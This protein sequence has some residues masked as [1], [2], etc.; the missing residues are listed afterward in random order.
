MGGGDAYVV[1]KRGAF[2]MHIGAIEP[3]TANCWR[4]RCRANVLTCWLRCV[5][6]IVRLGLGWCCWHF[7]KRVRVPAVGEVPVMGSCRRL[8]PRYCRDVA[9]LALDTGSTIAS[10]AR[11]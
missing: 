8:T 4:I 9:S 10:V 11:D 2:K 3:P 7:V 1:S 5:V 6:A